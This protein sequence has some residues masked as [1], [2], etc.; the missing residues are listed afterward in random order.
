MTRFTIA[1]LM[2]AV[3]LLLVIEAVNDWGFDRVSRVQRLQVAQRRTL[4]AIKDQD[5]SKPAHIVLLGNSL[6]LEGLN[7][8]RLTERT[9]LKALPVPYFV[10]A[11]EYYDWY[12]GL[13]RLFA[14]GMRP[15][16]ILLGLSP[17]QFASSNTRGEYSARYLFRWRDLITVAQDTKMDATTTSSFVLGRVSEYWSTRQITRGYLLGE[18]FPGVTTLLHEMGTGR[19]PAIPEATLEAVATERLSSL[20]ALCREHGAQF[21]FVVP[22]SYQKGSE[23]IAQVGRKLGITVLVPVR[24]DELDETSFQSDA[25]HLNEKGAAV[26]TNRLAEGLQILL[27]SQ[28]A[29]SKP[30][31]QVADVLASQTNTVKARSAF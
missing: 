27:Q 10:L 11:T 19:D 22:P 15:R 26:F 6:L 21:V 13:K 9:E 1:L 20:E 8:E 14:E 5:S 23:T 3:G 12:F 7:V 24:N 2:T 28:P 16:Y 25:F 31:Q 4:L 17:N 18:L 30:S 29:Q